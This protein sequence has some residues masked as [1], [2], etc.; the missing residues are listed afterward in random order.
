MDPRE[1]QLL[2][3][4]FKPSM[5][6]GQ[7]VFCKREQQLGSRVEGT[8]LCGTVDQLQSQFR[9]SREVADQAQRTVPAPGK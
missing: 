9:L 2:R 6:H 7:K 8:M 5:Q 4:G 1:K 3:M